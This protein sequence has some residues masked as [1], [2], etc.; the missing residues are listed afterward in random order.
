[1]FRFNYHHLRLPRSCISYAILLLIGSII[2]C[3]TII[4]SPCRFVNLTRC[5]C[6]Q[7]T[8][9]PSSKFPFPRNNISDNTNFILNSDHCRLRAPVWM[10]IGVISRAS[11]FHQRHAI[12]H[13]WGSVVRRT[14]ARNVC[15]IF[16]VGLCH[17]SVQ[18]LLEA[19]HKQ[20]G[21][22]VQV[23]ADDTYQNLVWKSV[24]LLKWTAEF[25]TSFS[26]LLK[27][28]DD[29]F[30][31]LEQLFNTLDMFESVPR[32]IMGQINRRS[33]PKRRSMSK[34]YVSRNDYPDDFYPTYVAGAAYVISG[35]LT[36]DLLE[37]IPNSP[38]VHVEDIFINGICAQRVGALLVGDCGFSTRHVKLEHILWYP[39]RLTFH[40]YTPS[41]MKELW[42]QTR[43]VA[44]N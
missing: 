43:Q 10:V 41:G 12:R 18:V 40:G 7:S 39:D 22:V 14:P 28:D 19:E 33:Q 20:Y 32:F 37:V 3:I 38:L 36:R 44:S 17:P 15:L 27:I 25:C 11:N 1:M 24:A 16:L 4:K 9:P 34:Y 2:L 26:F 23:N 6:I 8:R 31:N 30:V 35:L 29:V 5:C 42:K 21:D 13:T